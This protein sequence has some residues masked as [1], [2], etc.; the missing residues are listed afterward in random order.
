[1]L[2]LVACAP[3]APAGGAAPAQS[4]TNAAAPVVPA[5][6][7]EWERT[8]A[9]AR[10]EGT[11]VV[12]G[13]S[14]DRIR[15][16]AIDGFTKAFPGISLEWSSGRG[17]EMASK[18]D[19]ERRA[20]VYAVDVFI[21]G[22]TTANGQLKPMGAIEPLR[23]A[24]ILPTV[25]DPGQWRDQRLDFS[26][27]AEMNLVFAGQ[28]KALLLYDPKQVRPDEIDELPKL[29]DPRWRGRLVVNDPMPAGSGQATFRWFWETLGAE[30]ATE[31]YR[32]FRAQAGAVDR[33][34]RRQIEWVARGRYPVLLSPGDAVLDQLLE[35]GLQVEV[36]A[37]LKDYG[38]YL[39]ASSG[40]TALVNNAPHPNAARVFVN[41]LLS[42]EGQT[43]YSTAMNQAS[44]RLDVA[45]DHLEPYAVPKAD[46][47]YWPNYH[48]DNVLPPPAMQAVLRELFGS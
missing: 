17:T 21:G 22:T 45:T 5:W 41:W 37:E 46:R 4:Q 1:M 26:D 12:Y 2:L 19:A 28:V 29:L 38:G 9:A 48:E 36:L 44:R 7:V 18:I 6:Q 33:D 23:P 8:V 40:S 10:Q 27:R 3:A 30:R 24:L 34:Q 42:P 13:P 15:R 11:V 31:T 43:M 35:E 20:G 47:Q 39:T 32:A 16:A 14:G 25:S